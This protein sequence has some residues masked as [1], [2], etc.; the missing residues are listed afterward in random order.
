MFILLVVKFQ[1]IINFPKLK[2]VLKSV[3]NFSS[4]LNKTKLQFS[5]KM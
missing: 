1:N 3:K 4:G 5:F 2:I